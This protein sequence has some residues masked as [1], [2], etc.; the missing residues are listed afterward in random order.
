[1][2]KLRKKEE[3]AIKHVKGAALQEKEEPRAFIIPT[4]MEAKINLNV[5]ADT[6]SD[7]NVTPYRIY[8]NL[9]VRVNEM[10]SDEVLFKS[11]AWKHT[12]NINE[13]IYIE[14]CQEFYAAFKFNEAVANDELMT[15]EINQIRQCGK[16]YAMSILDFAK[17][18]GLYTGAEIQE[19][20]FETYFVGGLRNDDDFSVDQYWLNISSE[21]TLTFSRSS[22]K[23][24]R[25]LVLRVLQKMIAYGLCQRTTCYDKV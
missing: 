8:A 7:I 21:E 22:A 5:L 20:G 16:A 23:T 15:K 9:E 12:F 10:G 19:Y 14:L 3:E 6:G 1:M 17:H 24:I 13:I 18:L 2:E 11:K 25:K 4:Q